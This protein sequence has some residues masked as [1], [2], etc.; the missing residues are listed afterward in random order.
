MK[1]LFLSS[2]FP[3]PP[4]NGAKMR[5][6]NLL[7]YLTA[8]HEVTLVAFVN[9]L[10]PEV[11]QAELGK[12]RQI[13]RS[14]TAIPLP[15]RKRSLNLLG[16]LSLAPRH[17]VSAFDAGAM[18]TIRAIAEQD[19]YD[20]VVVSE[21]GPAAGMSYYAAQLSGSS[22]PLAQTPLILD[23]LEIGA[24]LDR[25]APVRPP[26]QRLRAALTWAKFRPYLRHLLRRF[27]LCTVPSAVEL[28]HVKDVAHEST[29]LA[30]LPHGLDLDYLT[31]CDDQQPAPYSVIF[32]GSLTYAPNRDAVE[33]YLRDIQ[34]RVKDSVPQLK[35]RIIGAL[36]GYKPQPGNLESDRDVEFKGLLA[37]VRP[38]VR[39]SWVSIVPLRQGSGTRLKIVESM[40]LGTPVVSTSK[41]AEGLDVTPGENILIADTPETFAQQIIRLLSDPALHKS[42]SENGR[43]LVEARYDRQFIG[44]QFNHMIESVGEHG[45]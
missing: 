1:I 13:T 36:G 41:G 23:G 15:Q 45:R 29:R 14:T 39:G 43:R 9:T 30:V 17:L 22:R 12:W 11:V 27:A 24:Y 33:Y 35:T 20:V 5:I 38:V 18:Q 28:N 6:N 31:P 10:K 8:R 42:L 4:L 32:S 44:E 25:L 7:W 26:L 16:F 3:S 40:A 37:D 21:V 2:W 19:R 34:P